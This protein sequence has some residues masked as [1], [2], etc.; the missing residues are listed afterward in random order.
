MRDVTALM[1]GTSDEVLALNRRHLVELSR[2]LHATW[3]QVDPGEARDRVAAWRDLWDG[4][5]DEMD[6]ARLAPDTGPPPSPPPPGESTVDEGV[7][8][9]AAVDPFAALWRELAADP[10]AAEYARVPPEGSDR[11]RWERLERVLRRV[12]ADAARTW[13]ERFAQVFPEADRA[14]L[15][16]EVPEDWSRRL[17]AVAE[18]FPDVARV[19]GD[20]R[21]ALEAGDREDAVS[22][23]EYDTDSLA[24]EGYK[25]YLNSLADLLVLF[26]RETTPA[27]RVVA[28]IALDE[29]LRSIVHDPLP[30]EGSWWHRTLEELR[31][32][33]RELAVDAEVEL[34]IPESR[35]PAREVREY[36]KVQARQ[37]GPEQSGVVLRVLRIAYRRDGGAWQEGRLLYAR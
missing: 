18:R 5:V 16:V 37:R 9:V 34:L 36:A 7:V 30:A 35:V 23:G 6:R 14:P 1:A 10:V 28:L 22:M 11:R 29:H 32:V 8:E 21:A 13:G 2:A 15:A 19:V 27:D 12:P 4:V 17:A 31:V 20:V 24:G 33:I 25:W 3:S 26:G